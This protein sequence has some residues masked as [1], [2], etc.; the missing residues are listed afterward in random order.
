MPQTMYSGEGHSLKITPC[1]TSMDLDT[2]PGLRRHI[3][4]IIGEAG[5]PDV[6]LDIS[7]VHWID[8]SGVALMLSLSRELR[9]RRKNLVIK[10][11]RDSFKSLLHF[12]QVERFF[13]FN[14]PG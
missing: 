9:S 13:T 8:S 6:I 5:Y 2:V 12:M 4:R 14:G 10:G 1:Q 3:N 11:E 7:R